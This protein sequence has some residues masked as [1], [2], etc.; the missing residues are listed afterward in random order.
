ME[1]QYVKKTV[2]AGCLILFINACRSGYCVGY[3]Q[4]C[5]SV[6]L[7]EN[8]DFNDIIESEMTDNEIRNTHINIGTGGDI[9]IKELAETIKGIVGFNGELYFNTD[10]PDGTMKKL[11][12]ASK[13]HAL[14]W[15][16]TMELRDGIQKLYDWYRLGT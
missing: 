12:D 8:R 13:L 4:W 6:Y 7:M 5:E 1:M 3:R 16:H 2:N 11:V 15:K 9:S 10:K 14:G